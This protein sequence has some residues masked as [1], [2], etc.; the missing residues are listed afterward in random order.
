MDSYP[1]CAVLF[2]HVDFMK[3]RF[4][5]VPGLLLLLLQECTPTTCHSVYL[6]VAEFILV[7]RQKV[8]NDPP[9][10]TLL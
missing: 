6:N 9:V 1:R 8:G 2:I 10:L 4:G 5:F 3:F 7:L